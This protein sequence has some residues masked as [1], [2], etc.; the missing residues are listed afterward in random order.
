MYPCSCLRVSQLAGAGAAFL[1]STIQASASEQQVLHG[2]LPPAAKN[3]QPIGRLPAKQKLSLAIGLPLRDPQGLAGLLEQIYDP[4]SPKY[5]QYLTAAQFAETFGPSRQ[6]YQRVMEFARTNGLTITADH[7]NRLLLDV[8]GAVADIERAFHVNLLLYQHPIESRAFYAPDTEPIAPASAPILHISGLDNY[9]IPRPAG[10]RP[11]PAHPPGGPAPQAG[12][13]PSGTY[14]GKDFRG[15]YA[16]GVS[17]D[18]SGQIVGLFE[19]DGFYPRDIAT[20]Q[21]QASLPAVPVVAVTLDGFDGTPGSRTIEVALD[22]EMVCSMAPGLSQIIVYEGPFPSAASGPVEDDILNRMATDNLAKQLSASWTFPVD[23]TT[24]QIF[25]EFAAQG[26]SYFNASGDN[27]A[28]SGTVSTPCDDTNITCVGGTFLTTTGPGGAWVSETVWNRGNSEASGGGISTRYRIPSWQR[29]V[30]MN[31]NHGSSTMRNLPDVAAVADNVWV[32]YSNGLSLAVG[33]T[34]CSSPLWAGFTAL[35]NQQAAAFGRPPV[36]FLNP[37]IY[38]IGLSAGYT[39]NFHD[40]ISGGNT[41]S[42]SPTQ[43]FAVHGFDLCT[44]WGTPFGQNLINTLAPRFPAPVITN[45]GATLIFEGCSSPNG[46]VN[47]GETVT[48]NFSLKNLGGLETTNLVAALRADDAVLYPSGPQSY[49]ALAGGNAAV[50]RPFTFTANGACGATLT[51]T[52]DLQDGGASLGTLKFDF[53]LGQPLTVFTQNFDAVTAPALPSD[54]TTT[55]S[56][57]VVAWVTSTNAF[58]TAPN[59]AFAQEPPVPGVEELFSPPIAIV[60]PV[61][62]LSFRNSFNTETDPTVVSRA[63]DGGVLEIQIG[64]NSFTDILAAGGSFVSGGYNRTIS[65]L[66]NDNPLTGRQAWGGNSGGFITTLVN[67]PAAAAGQTIQL[68]W[69]FGLDDGNFYGGSGWY[70]DTISIADGASCC[71]SSADLA[72]LQSASPE[73]VA[74]GQ[75]LT[76]SVAIANLGPGPASEVAITNTLPS[77]VIF[78]SGS[79]GCTYTNGGVLCDVGILALGFVTNFTFTVIPTALDPITNIA[80]IG[81]VTPDPNS[82]NNTAITVSTV[83]TSAPPFISLQQTNIVAV[84]G[85]L[86]TLQVAAFGVPPLGY[87]WLFNGSPL[88]G[89]T[90]PTLSFTNLQPEQSGAYSVVVTNV[91]GATTSPVVQLTVVAPLV[92]PLTGLAFSGTNLSISVSSLTGLSYTLQF[93]DSLTDATWTPILPPTPGTGGTLLLQD[94]NAAALPNRFYR[95]SAR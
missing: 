66:T 18:G 80:V 11:M 48:V 4:A 25:L 86:T 10:L 27:G 47:P 13:G 79:P 8:S 88:A 2:H 1:L 68:R 57:G 20:Y 33:G 52:L 94:T 28:Y 46:A 9:F 58:D 89:Q 51:A 81:S 34:S 3:L 67:L 29:A 23:A 55:A 41:T 61:A 14:R 16:R 38:H 32:T 50:S 22:I 95:I 77:T 21:R 93:K 5:H 65:T 75:P 24:E 36:G 83:L 76:Y 69:R 60:S 91:N 84:R 59:A 71:T 42:S 62:Q 64:T 17:L 19:L 54:W 26:Q 82:V 72:I 6:A 90:A 63:Y 70:I 45:A 31:A 44:G 78:S 39:T 53:P 15:A 74:P 87:Q 73:P 12:S 7:P 35:V 30:N 40:I 56:N 85:A 49:G 92:I 43:F 37:A